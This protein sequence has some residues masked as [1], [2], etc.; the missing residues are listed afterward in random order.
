MVIAAI[1]AVYLLYLTK[2]TKTSNMPREQ[3]N[4]NSE[5]PQYKLEISNY[6]ELEQLLLNRQIFTNGATY[7]GRTHTISHLNITLKKSSTGNLST[8]WANEDN[9]ERTEIMSS[10]S[11]V[12]D[13]TLY[14]NIYL[15]DK[16]G[17]MEKKQQLFNGELMRNLYYVSRDN[18]PEG[19]DYESV[20]KEVFQKAKNEDYHLIK[21]IDK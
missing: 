7:D 18:V 21:I 20:S 10:E 16:P 11:L 5:Y 9:S 8:Y 1:L 15:A 19:Y 3:I 13:D 12:E 2:N 17:V 4:L 14:I 6:V